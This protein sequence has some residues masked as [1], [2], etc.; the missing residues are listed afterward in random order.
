MGKH[1]SVKTGQTQSEIAKKRKRDKGKFAKESSGRFSP[2][3]SLKPSL[4]IEVASVGDENA[5]DVSFERYQSKTGVLGRQNALIAYLDAEDG[6]TYRIVGGGVELFG[7]VLVQVGDQDYTV[8][9]QQTFNTGSLWLPPER[10]EIDV[11]TTDSAEEAVEIARQV[12]EY[13]DDYMPE[14]PEPLYGFWS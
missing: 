13:G 12:H 7:D 10:E 2:S 5:V 6:E 11:A 8:V 1:N 14:E 3:T 9:R 4:G